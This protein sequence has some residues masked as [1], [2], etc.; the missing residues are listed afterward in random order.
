MH[1]RAQSA[2]KVKLELENLSIKDVEVPKNMT[3]L[4]QHLDLTTNRV[5]K[6][7]KQREFSDYFTNCITEVSPAGSKQGVTAI[8]VD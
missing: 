6:K 2:E 5:V 8:K 3:H 7:M 1:F 4:L